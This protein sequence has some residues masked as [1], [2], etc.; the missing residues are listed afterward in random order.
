MRTV[1]DELRAMGHV[2]EDDRAG[3]LLH[4]GLPDLSRYPAGSAAAPAIGAHDR[5]VS[6]PDCTATSPPK[7][8][9]GCR[10]GAGRCG[11]TSTSPPPF[12]TRFPVIP[13]GPHRP[14]ARSGVCAAALVPCRRPRHDG[15]DRESAPRIGNARFSQHCRAW[16][17]GVD[18]EL[19]R[20]EAATRLG[21]AGPGVPVCRPGRGG[22]EHR[23]VSRPR[24]AGV[25]GGGRR[26]PAARVLA[27]APSGRAFC[28]RAARGGAGGGLCRCRR[29]RVSLADRYV[30]LVLLEALAC[31][32]PV[33]AYPVTGPVDVLDG[34]GS[35]GA[36][37]SDHAR[38]LP[39]ARCAPIGWPAGPMP[40]GSPG[41]PAPSVP[42]QPGSADQDE[43][44][45]RCDNG[46]RCGMRPWG[47]RSR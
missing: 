13:A 45:S 2:V 29:V 18:L 40:S 30:R 47:A 16:S 42:C 38:R 5:G 11:T 9:S 14:F 32:T 44:V 19:F 37:N 34:A 39:C 25:E 27:T 6:A 1:V 46:P 12:N 41:E 33:A 35:V 3:P 36:L 43:A 7:G 23:R 8:R 21:A 28:R 17:R 10:R 4:R 22:E 26:R 20:P 31:G 15:G 24:P